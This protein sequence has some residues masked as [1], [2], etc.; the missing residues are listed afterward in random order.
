[1]GGIVGFLL[2]ICAV[3]FST[4]HFLAFFSLE[5]LMIVVGGVIAVAFMSFHEHDV[6]TALRAIRNMFTDTPATHASLHLDMIDILAWARIVREKGLPGLES[7]MGRKGVNDPFVRY[8]LNMVITDYTPAEVRAMMETA[9]DAYYERDS[10]PVQVLQAMASHAPAFGMIGTLVGM[11]TMLCSLNENIAGMGSSLAVSFLSTL[12]G[13]VTARMFYMPAA[14][15]LQQKLDCQYFRNHLVVEGM[16]MLVAGKSPMYI[17][18]RLNS[19]LRPEIHDSLNT[20]IKAR[21]HLKLQAAR[22]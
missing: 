8:G 7:S 19:F 17:Q 9:A 15:K 18:D 1:M 16:V 10:V 4:N 22:A 13:V 2:I 21:P 14:A 11:I 5:G 3:A 6:E 12:Y 20:T